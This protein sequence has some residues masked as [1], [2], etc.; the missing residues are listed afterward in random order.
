MRS[1][2]VGEIEGRLGGLL[3]SLLS[4]QVSNDL[5]ITSHEAIRLSGPFLRALVDAFLADKIVT[6]TWPSVAMLGAVVS[7]HFLTLLAFSPELDRILVGIVVL[8]SLCWSVYGLTKGAKA[9]WPYVRLWF[10]TLLP[11]A[12]YARLLIFQYVREQYAAITTMKAGEGFKTDVLKAAWEQFQ[13]E[14]RVEPEQVAFRLADH[15]APVLVRHLLQRTAAL[16][17]PVLCAFVYYRLVI[18]LD[19]IARY[20]TI[21]PWSIAIYPL[22]ALADGLM[23]THLRT[24]LQSH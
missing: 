2:K 18:Y 22:A 3:G 15:L 14:N 13:N 6:A 5:A 1:K 24:A 12:R 20:T 10:V 21:G 16:V 19:I 8:A 23:D 4:N 9:A 7:V 17:G 11:P